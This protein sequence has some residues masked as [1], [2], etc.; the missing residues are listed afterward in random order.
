[1]NNY[2]RFLFVLLLILMCFGGVLTLN[3]VNKYRKIN[4]QLKEISSHI[5]DINRT[6]EI[7]YDGGSDE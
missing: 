4:A 2:E 7:E 3:L 1:M 6:L 5:D